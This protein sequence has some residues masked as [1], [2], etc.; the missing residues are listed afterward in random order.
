MKNKYMFLVL[1]ALLLNIWL[2]YLIYSIFHRIDNIEVYLKMSEV[3][4][5]NLE[6]NR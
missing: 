1:I 3:D 6:Y 2:L 5:T 4:I